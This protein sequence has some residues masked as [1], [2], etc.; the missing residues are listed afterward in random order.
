MVL[1]RGGPNLNLLEDR[2]I[3]IS[4]RTLNN[5]AYIVVEASNSYKVGGTG[6][7][8]L[9]LSP[10]SDPARS[11]ACLENKCTIGVGRASRPAV[12]T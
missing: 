8:R 4:A 1:P 3:L 5:R 10:D 9:C 2:T 7:I 12:A 6:R 11:G